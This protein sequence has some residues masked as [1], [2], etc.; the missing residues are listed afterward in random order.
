VILGSA[1]KQHFTRIGVLIDPY[2][3]GP[4]AEGGYEVTL[5]V[6]PAVLRAVK[7][8]YRALFAHGR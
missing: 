7:P 8:E 3:A 4:Y 2:A 6:T 1:D 5:P